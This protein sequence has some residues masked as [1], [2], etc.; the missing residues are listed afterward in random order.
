MLF[1]RFIIVDREMYLPRDLFLTRPA[2][3]HGPHT[4][5]FRVAITVF[6]PVFEHFQQFL[7]RF[8]IRMPMSAPVCMAMS[9]MFM[10]IVHSSS[11]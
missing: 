2:C 8:S 6:D 1:Y 3:L 7:E 5:V 11:V 4:V 9:M 10:I